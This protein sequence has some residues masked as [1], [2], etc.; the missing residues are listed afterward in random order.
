MGYSKNPEVTE[1][2]KPVLDYL[3]ALNKTVTTKHK[4]PNRFLYAIR[5][6]LH[7]AEFNGVTKYKEI[8]NK[9]KFRV[10]PGVH[11]VTFEL[12]QDPTVLQETLVLTDEKAVEPLDV[13]GVVIENQ[14]QKLHF[15][16]AT[17][18]AFQVMESWANENNYLSSWTHQTGLTLTKKQEKEVRD[19]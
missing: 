16:N 4:Y 18:E 13:L 7:A 10:G 2:M 11:Q 1:K 9:F 15:P 17:H 6:A 5:E 14:V 12:K 3:L 19:E 8:K